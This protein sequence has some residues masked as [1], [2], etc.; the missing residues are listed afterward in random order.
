MGDFVTASGIRNSENLELDGLANPQVLVLGSELHLAA[1][2][3]AYLIDPVH[4]VVG[5]AVV[6]LAV[7]EDGVELVVSPNGH[8]CILVW[9]RSRGQVWF[10]IEAAVVKIA[11]ISTMR[12]LRCSG[13]PYK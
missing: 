4:R 1:L 6:A 11:D 9:E 3:R 12:A 2:L 5:Q 10:E 7:V 13:A 8:N